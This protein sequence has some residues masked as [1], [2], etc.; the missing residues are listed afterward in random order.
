FDLEE[1]KQNRNKENEINRRV[2][3]LLYRP[4]T[5]VDPNKWP[6]PSVK[7]GV[8]GCIARF[9]SDAKTRRQNLDERREHKD[10]P[11]RSDMD[12][13]FACRFYDRQTT[14]SPCEGSDPSSDICFCVPE[15]V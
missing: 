9:H 7:Q 10:E 1:N 4:G 6:C 11:D 8:G 13:T 3:V 14:G 12:G 5:L 2:M 15:T